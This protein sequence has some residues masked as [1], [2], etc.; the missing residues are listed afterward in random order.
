MV[1]A[2]DVT[3]PECEVPATVSCRDIQGRVLV[4]CHQ[5]RHESA[6]AQHMAQQGRCA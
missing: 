5:A 4:D 1:S 3:C 2:Y 6:M